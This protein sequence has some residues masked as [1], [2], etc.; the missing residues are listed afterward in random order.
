MMNIK[1][2]G[3]ICPVLF[4]VFEVVLLNDEFLCAEVAVLMC[5]A[6]PIHTLMYKHSS[7]G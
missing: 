3:S 5:K 2:Q 6:Q 7:Q 4:C 1:K